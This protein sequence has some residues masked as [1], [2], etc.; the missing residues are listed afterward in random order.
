MTRQS[1]V[2]RAGVLQHYA[3]TFNQ[4]RAPVSRFGP[5]AA[6]E[7]GPDDLVMDPPVHKLV[8][9]QARGLSLWTH[10]CRCYGIA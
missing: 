5:A 8:S 1:S 6:D 10:A 7:P 2:L 9:F 4:A 3:L